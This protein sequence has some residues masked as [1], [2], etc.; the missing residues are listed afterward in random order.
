[1]SSVERPFP[2]VFSPPLRS[3]PPSSVEQMTRAFQGIRPFRSFAFRITGFGHLAKT[4]A[5]LALAIL[6]LEIL[7]YFGVRVAVPGIPLLAAIV[8]MGFSSGLRVGLG[9]T[10]IGILYELLTFSDEQHW[11]RYT[12]ENWIRIAIFSAAALTAAILVGIQ[13]KRVEA[14]TY[15]LAHRGAAETWQSETESLQSVLLQV[16]LGLLVADAVSGEITFAN[17]KARS[18]LGSNIQRLHS[19]GFPSMNHIDTGRCYG[20]D[21]W[22]LRRCV[23]ARTMI[24]EDFLYVRENG[25][26]ALIHARSYPIYNRAGELIAAVMS[27]S[28]AAETKCMERRLADVALRVESSKAS[29]LNAHRLKEYRYA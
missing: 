23:A 28:E 2:A 27:F 17:D 19:V 4:A 21:E 20:P 26:M 25:Q 9:A 29:S 15:A 24:E 12:S 11:F 18:I 10:S 1:M 22:P 6:G 13:R 14:A 7:H 16:P 3:S 8:W 5:P